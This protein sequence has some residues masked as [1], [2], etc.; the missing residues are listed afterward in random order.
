[1]SDETIWQE[2]RSNFGTTDGWKELWLGLKHCFIGGNNCAI[3]VRDEKAKKWVLTLGVSNPN[4]EIP[5]DLIDKTTRNSIAITDPKIAGFVRAKSVM[6]TDWEMLNAQECG[7]AMA[8]FCVENNQGWEQMI[9]AFI[10][11][12]RDD[13]FPKYRD[14]DGPEIR[15]M[16]ITA[17]KIVL[18]E[19][20]QHQ[21]ATYSKEMKAGTKWG[22]H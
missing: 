4:G 20:A 21:I 12:T 9:L 1:L 11:Q 5:A 3:Y 13:K 7:E 8:Q 2:I 16:V 14:S 19:L 17:Y 15:W 18:N 22:D 10:R 6:L